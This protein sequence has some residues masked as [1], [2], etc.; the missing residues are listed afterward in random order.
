VGSDTKVVRSFNVFSPKSTQ[1]LRQTNETRGGNVRGVF[2]VVLP[3]LLVP[4]WAAAFDST[5]NIWLCDLLYFQ[6]M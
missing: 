2:S 6:P 1:A 5:L 3:P 4:P